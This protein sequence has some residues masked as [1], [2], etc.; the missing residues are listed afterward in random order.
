MNNQNNQALQT[1]LLATMAMI[2]LLG[3]FGS[4]FAQGVGTL[5]DD[6][7]GMWHLDGDATNRFTFGKNGRFSNQ[8]NGKLEKG[9]YRISDSAGILETKI[10]RGTTR[11]K[12][13]IDGDSLFIGIGNDE[14]IYKRVRRDSAS[15]SSNSANNRRGAAANNDVDLSTPTKAFAAYY[16]A[17]E[18]RNANLFRRVASSRTIESMSEGAAKQ[19]MKF[20]DD[21][22]RAYLDKLASKI[23]ETPETRNEK[24]NGDRATL[25]E[26]LASGWREVVCVKENGAWKYDSFY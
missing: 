18:S 19:Q 10:A 24:I 1:I 16:R 22:I 8:A 11:F 3:A 14:L 20:D 7:V 12:V 4:A 15:D 23:S 21:F 26:K 9:T 6:I 25:E 13:K 2:F 5:S 17:V